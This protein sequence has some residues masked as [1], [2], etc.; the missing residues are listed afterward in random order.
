[1]NKNIFKIFTSVFCLCSFVINA[2]SSMNGFF[3]SGGEAA[4]NN[5][6]HL[7]QVIGQPFVGFSSNAEYF[8]SSGSLYYFSGITTDVD[9]DNY[10]GIPKNYS[11]KQNYPNPFNPTTKIVYAIPKSGIVKIKV[12]DILGREVVNLINEEQSAGYHELIFYASALPSG[13]YF[14]NIIADNFVQT[15]KMILMK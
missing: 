8:L 9:D 6:Y 15:K 2:Q 11:L 5:E 12:Y 1:M 3:S 4:S 14:Y 13:I 10:S 7:N